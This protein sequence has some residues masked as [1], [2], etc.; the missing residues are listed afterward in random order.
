MH[1]S[2]Q[3]NCIQE[4]CRNSIAAEK[5]GCWTRSRALFSG[6]PARGRTRRQHRKRRPD[7]ARRSGIKVWDSGMASGARRRPQGITRGASKLQAN[8]KQPQASRR[9]AADVVAQQSTL[10]AGTAIHQRFQLPHIGRAQVFTRQQGL[11][12]FKNAML[13]HGWQDGCRRTNGDTG[14]ADGQPFRRGF[15]LCPTGRAAT[16]Q[17]SKHADQYTGP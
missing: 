12:L 16:Q 11:H 7:L 10:A 2:C 8:C 4:L 3:V 17:P 14:H 5:I 1:A 15:Q 6:A 13:R 9:A